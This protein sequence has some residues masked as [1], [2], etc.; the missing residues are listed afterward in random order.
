MSEETAVLEQQ[1]ETVTREFATPNELGGFAQVEREKLDAPAGINASLYCVEQADGW[2]AL[3]H[4]ILPEGGSIKQF[5]IQLPA[6]PT[7]S[8]ALHAAVRDLAAWS[9]DQIE[10]GSV[11]HRKQ[12]AKLLAWAR[13]LASEYAP[14]PVYPDTPPQDFAGIAPQLY[15][16]SDLHVSPLNPRGEVADED[17]ESLAASI[18]EH[19]FYSWLPII[20][21]PL[22]TGGA[23]IAAGHRRHKAALR[24]GK[25][26]VPAL[27]VDMTDEQ[28]LKILYFDNSGREDVHPLKEAAAWAHWKEQSG[29]SIE[30][31]GIRAGLGK[32]AA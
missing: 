8:E 21:R 32:A 7:R 18:R 16:L 20:A 9:E 10:K 22:P 19:G 27:I 17:I 11:K 2:R 25:T 13:G 1:S 31:I 4:A 14:A 15:P 5:N 29:E 30:Q 26:H 23:E 28:F 12:A 6:Y 3:G 24:A